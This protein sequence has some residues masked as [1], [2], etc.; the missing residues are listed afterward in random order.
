YFILTI[1]LGTAIF[2]GGYFL[3]ALLQ[4]N[5]ISTFWTMVLPNPPPGSCVDGDIIVAATY[6]ASAINALADWCFG[7]LPI[8]IVRSLQMEYRQKI[9][10]AVI[11]AV[12][13]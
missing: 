8:F 4:C 7:I 5:P 2:G 9:L 11:L 6:A 3:L 10:V 13:A 1:I 12:G